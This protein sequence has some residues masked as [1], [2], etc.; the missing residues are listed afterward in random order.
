MNSAQLYLPIVLPQWGI[1]AGVVLITIGY[2]DKK[3]L[4]TRLGWMVLIATGLIALYFNLFGGLNAMAEKG[5]T[6][7]MASLLISTGWQAVAGGALAI[8]S[9][10]MLQFKAKRY[11]ILAILTLLYFFLTFF[12]Y[13]QVSDSSEIKIK[14]S[15][16]TEQ[17]Q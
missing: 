13:S 2:V 14:T 4:W 17:K 3:H 8:I 12:L 16:P 9:L 10:L 11:S 7:N 5:E 6:S 15:I 1:F